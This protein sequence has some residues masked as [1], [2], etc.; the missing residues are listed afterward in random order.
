MYDL[1]GVGRSL[2]G[3]LDPRNVP[4]AVRGLRTARSGGAAH[5]ELSRMPAEFLIGPELR[6]ER[7]HYCG[8]AADYLPLGE[9][10]A[11]ASED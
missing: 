2:W 10:F 3:I 11:W 9:V 4:H 5:G 8:F 6:I 1:Y 7:A